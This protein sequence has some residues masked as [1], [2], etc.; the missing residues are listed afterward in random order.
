MNSWFCW[1]VKSKDF[2]ASTSCLRCRSAT[3][4][5]CDLGEILN[6]SVLKFPKRGQKQ[7]ANHVY[8]MKPLWIWN[9]SIC[10]NVLKIV[11]NMFKVFNLLCYYYHIKWTVGKQRV[12]IKLWKFFI[13]IITYMF[14]KIRNIE[15]RLN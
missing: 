11:P 12:K 3:Y 4:L 2:G 7:D 15:C 1:S 10:F 5:P 9:N 6:L 8:I 13:Y 14:K